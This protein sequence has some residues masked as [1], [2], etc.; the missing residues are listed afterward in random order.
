[1]E[2][3][4][5]LEDIET[6]ENNGILI[7]VLSII[8]TILETDFWNSIENDLQPLTKNILKIY[9]LK[10]NVSDWRV[11]CLEILELLIDYDT[12]IRLDKMIKIFKQ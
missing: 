6:S 11:L 9:N 5:N 12:S 3:L 10:E 4:S 8:K 7:R 2:K 1:M